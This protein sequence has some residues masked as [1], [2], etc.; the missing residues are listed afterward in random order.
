MYNDDFLIKLNK[1]NRKSKIIS[2]VILTTVIIVLLFLIISVI[3]YNSNYMYK[4]Y[5]IDNNIYY[6]N[7][8][9]GCL[10]KMQLRLPD[11]KWVQ[12]KSFELIRKE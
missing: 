9:N 10:S 6:C 8:M 7:F 1:Y 2:N 11:G 12:L 4:C 3:Y 5:D